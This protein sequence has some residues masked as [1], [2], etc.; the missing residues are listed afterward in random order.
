[1]S[2]VCKTLESFGDSKLKDL[3]KWFQANVT[4]K[5]L[6]VYSNEISFEFQRISHTMMISYD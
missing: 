6:A 2:E 5:R 3:P 4:P 1:M